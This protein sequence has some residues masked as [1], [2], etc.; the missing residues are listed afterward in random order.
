[1][2]WQVVH[3]AHLTLY[4]PACHHTGWITMEQHALTVMLT[5]SNVHQ[6]LNVQFVKMGII[7]MHTNVLNVWVNVIHVT[8]EIH[9][10][11]ASR[12][13]IILI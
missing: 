6:L 1:M 7:C 10:L 5:V 12:M 2:D 13:D 9:A 8:M 11:H 3:N 4:Y